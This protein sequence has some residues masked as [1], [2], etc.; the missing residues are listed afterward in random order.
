MTVQPADGPQTAAPAEPAPDPDHRLVAWREAYL[1]GGLPTPDQERRW[2]VLRAGVAG[3]W[4]F[5]ATEY[6]YAGGWAQLTGRNETGKSSLMALTTLIPWL[7]D[8][9]PNN[10][11]TLGASAR[12]KNFRY[13]VEP[14]TGDGDRRDAA[15]TTSHG[16]L[17]VEYGRIVDGMPRY[18][19]TLGYFRAQ[20][21][22]QSDYRRTW[23]TA[24]GTDRVRRG[25]DLVTARSVHQPKDVARGTG[26]RV[27][28]SG[29]EY[30]Q[31]V[32]RHLLG[33]DVDGLESVG[34]LLRVI[35]TPKLG[36]SL[37]ESFVT[38]K[39]RDSLPGLETAEVSKLATGWDELDKV[40]QEMEVAGAAVE[41]LARYLRGTW[42]PYLSAELRHSADRA[43]DARTRF[44]NVAREVRLATEARDRAQ[45]DLE[46]VTEQQN[47][48]Q[49]ALDADLEAE[50]RLRRTSEFRDAKDRLAEVERT[51]RDLDAAKDLLAAADIRLDLQKGRVER[52]G[53]EAAAAYTAR[54][55]AGEALSRSRSDLLTRLEAA[56]LTGRDASVH[57]G[58][59]HLVDRLL[60]DR[61]TQLTHVGTLFAKHA[62]GDTQA[63]QAETT[64]DQA[65]HRAA[66]T[67]AGAEQAWRLAEEER[68]ALTVRLSTWVAALPGHCPADPGLLDDLVALLPRD[69]TRQAVRLTDRVRE[70][71]HT[72][73][74]TDIEDRLRENA[75]HLDLNAA[76]AAALTAEADQL[77]AAADP[78]IRPSQRLRRRERPDTGGAPLW[79]LLDAPGVPAADLSAV[80]A[81]LTAM[82]LIDVWVSDDGIFRRQRDGLDTVLTGHH[83]NPAP[84]PSLADLLTTV[85]SSRAAAAVNRLLAAIAWGA[86]EDGGDTPRGY[87]ISPEG[88]WH[89]PDRAGRA[90]LHTGDAELIGETAR[91]A[92][93]ERRLAAI[94]DELAALAATRNALQAD[95]AAL[96]A[97]ADQ[98]GQTL[99][100]A[101]TDDHLRALLVR[102]AAADE[103]AELD[104]TSATAAREQATQA[105]GRA[106]QSR[107]T[108]F[109][110]AGRFTLPTTGAD[111]DALRQR[112]GDA[113]TALL[114]LTHA[115][116]QFDRCSRAL[117]QARTVLSEEESVHRAETQTRQEA[118]NHCAALDAALTQLRAQLTADAA[119]I[120][121][122]VQDLESAI[123][124]TRARLHDLAGRR[125]NL[126]GAHAAA[127]A[128][129]KAEEQKRQER[130]AERAAAYADF[131]ELL[132]L[133]VPQDL[134]LDLPQPEAR[135]VEAT[136]HQVAVVREQVKP[137]NWPEN[138]SDA[139]RQVQTLRG[140]LAT[141][142]GLR[143][144][145]AGGRTVTLN[146]TGRLPRLEIVI[147]A[148]GTPYDARRA[149]QGLEQ[150]HT[151]LRSSYDDTI[152]RNLEELLGSTF[153]D[154]LRFQ[155]ATGYTL[156]QE[157]NDVLRRH[158]TGTTRTILRIVLTPREGSDGAVL[159]TLRGSASLMDPGTADH[160]R[161]FLRTRIEEA[162]AV[163]ISEGE[164]EWGDRLAQALDYRTWWDVKLQKRAGETGRWTPVNQ[165]SYAMQSGGARVVMLMLPLVATLS[166]LYRSMPSAP[167]PF[168]LDEA[169]DGLDQAN[170]QMV[171][172]LL[173]EFD[174]DVLL[175]GPGRLLNSP[176]VP[177][178]AMYQVVRADHPHPG[179]DLTCELWAGGELTVLQPDELSIA[180]QDEDSLFGF[181][182]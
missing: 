15:A 13:Y 135:T 76:A 105:R 119:G 53:K 107:A 71:W 178:A 146:P 152:R 163:S 97:R 132:D 164:V 59:H 130:E 3:L 170:R 162:R 32:A 96:A 36:Q 117:E 98:L 177:A 121:T 161:N 138:G 140:R 125:E 157:I 41:H 147:D 40:R 51:G 69:P 9:S 28:A 124:A 21:A 38:D 108:A 149:M 158:P 154:H 34:K 49:A 85:T 56:G 47:S 5:E 172:E 50:R 175:A 120:L 159:E 136:R 141:L 145:E 155:L 180:G 18:F 116:E 64:A 63:R 4:E 115:I 128:T 33:A 1:A 43:A 82:G 87:A 122:Q 153:I 2:Q 78:V 89:T 25:L 30:K 67:S 35:R 46:T 81:G 118:E 61:S 10:I 148:T 104:R 77:R 17:W 48:A 79:R 144:L 103:R 127:G 102:A 73:H 181:G 174:F 126:V 45:T 83:L 27:H 143:T 55:N 65:E 160:V 169:F 14:T 109:D 92:A 60:R 165:A 20:R 75:S 42:R 70:R 95:A 91:Q 112:L 80:E 101:P 111:R 72:P 134:S 167:H 54:E 150:I 19:T 139:A 90:E 99:A 7:A 88:S 57:D 110:Y 68:E 114:G 44:D 151:E 129:L 113:A 6:W 24:E 66:E 123:G 26:V 137:R 171:L 179:A 22:N 176:A 74:R 31:H 182:S 29:T 168:W 106:H 93:R 16:W 84:G 156:V 100:D 12:G 173:A 52:A 131:H 23:V 58:D 86:D 62:A 11:D 133:G 8:V 37:S 39:L 142:D 94:D 166:A